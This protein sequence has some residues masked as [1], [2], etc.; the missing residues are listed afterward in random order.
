MLH[1]FAIPLLARLGLVIALLA[2][3]GLPMTQLAP[4]AHPKSA[5]A[6]ERPAVP[7]APQS[8]VT[9]NP[10]AD[11]TISVGSPDTNLG[12][13]ALLWTQ[14]GSFMKVQSDPAAGVNTG[15]REQAPRSPAWE[16]TQRALLRFDL[17]AGVVIDAARLLLKPDQAGGADSVV[18]T[19]YQITSDWTEMG[20]TWNN[21][22][23]R[24][25][26]YAQG[27]VGVAT[28]WVAWDVTEIARAWQAGPNYGLLLE[29]AEPTTV[30]WYR[31]FLSRDRN[32][33]QNLPQLVVTYHL[34]NATLYAPPGG[35]PGAELP[36][37]GQN[38]PPSAA[39]TLQLER[40]GS[41]WSCGSANADG[42]G[43]LQSRC[44]VPL[45]LP[46]GEA[47][48]SARS[49]SGALLAS[50]AVQILAGPGLQISPAS[51]PPGTVVQYSV[52]N[53]VA[54]SLRLDYDGVPLVG[55]RPV[56]SGAAS[57]SF[58]VP[59]DRPSPLG[60]ATAVKAVNIAGRQSAGAAEVVFRSQPATAPPSFQFT[61][62]S[63]SGA[64]LVQNQ[65][66]FSVTARC[67]S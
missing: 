9:L 16:P 2:P 33:V 64:H 30:V 26:L 56:A 47:V 28:S 42:A 40:G 18:L 23:P 21:Q 58:V 52:T 44:T 10:A 67:D 61:S 12:G 17:P 39:I 22:P 19:A 41:S 32:P 63:A 27:T 57:G 13:D 34:P 25:S 62:A 7:A 4:P 31:S 35:R 15:P 55:P 37:A 50:A 48:L 60:S 45:A 66:T 11:A 29:P 6:V 51:G 43:T 38:Y 36:V 54:G 59:A 3:Q 49:V 14:M 53:L 5:P 20:V 8:E 46:V 1:A 65:A 24:G